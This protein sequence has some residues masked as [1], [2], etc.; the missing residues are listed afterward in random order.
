MS[1]DRNIVVPYSYGPIVPFVTQTHEFHFGLEEEYQLE[2]ADM[3][4]TGGG[5]LSRPLE[6]ITKRG[7][8]LNVPLVFRGPFILATCDDK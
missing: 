7:G 3:I 4:N 8:D 2:N 5:D 1:P 6:Y